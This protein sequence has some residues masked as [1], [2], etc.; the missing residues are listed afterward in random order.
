M[1]FMPGF[2]GAPTRFATDFGIYPTGSLPAD[3]TLQNAVTSPTVETLA[4]AISGRALR[5][6]SAATT[7]PR[8]TWNRVPSVAD[9]EILGRYQLETSTAASNRQFLQL[10]RFA[11]INNYYYFGAWNA[12]SSIYTKNLTK[13]V[14]GSGT[15]IASGTQ[16]ITPIA[17][18]DWIYVRT[19]LQGSNISIKYWKSGTAEPGSW[20]FTTTDASLTAAGLVGILLA[21]SAS[22]AAQN[23][24]CDYFAV[25]TNKQTIAVPV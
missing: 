24:W 4:G 3:W 16:N 8:V 11:D 22:V 23:M 12:G 14:A 17:A 5:L 15:S 7:S 13:V 1:S 25:D 20:T 21:Y 10:H 9:C 6:S 19:L 2:R 18:G